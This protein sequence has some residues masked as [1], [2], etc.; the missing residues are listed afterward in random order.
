VTSTPG[1]GSIGF[2]TNPIYID[3][4]PSSYQS[5]GLEDD[6]DLFVRDDL[7]AEEILGRE[8]DLLVQVERDIITMIL[9]NIFGMLSS[10]V[11][12]FFR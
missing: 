12:L 5:R 7:D 9:I 1:T 2:L 6:E 11:S 3:Q 10:L 8:Y 4:I